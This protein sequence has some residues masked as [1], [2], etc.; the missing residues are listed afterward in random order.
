MVALGLGC[1][2]VHMQTT[3]E[4]MLQMQAGS[5]WE[6]ESVFFDRMAGQ[7]AAA[8]IDPLVFQRY[9]SSKRRRF[10]EEFRFRVLDDLCGKQVLDVGCADGHNSIL[11]AKL[12]ASVTGIDIS[13]K[14]IELARERACVNEVECST[15]FI[16]SPIE[17]ANI[18]PASFD[19]IWGDCVLHHL[20]AEQ[21]P[22]M[23]RLHG[24]LKP[25]GTMLFSEPVNFNNALR[26][27]RMKIP[28]HTEATPDE[29][30]LEPSEIETIRAYLPDMQIRFYSL[31]SRFS[32]FVLLDRFDYEHSSLP[33]RAIFNAMA[34]IDYA[35][36][37]VPPLRNMGRTHCKTL[38]K[39]IMKQA[40]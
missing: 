22:L 14:S 26:R 34:L 2:H 12:G 4:A 9:S 7:Q 20:I 24:W 11:L 8:A 19:V 16:C 18:P 25:G 3:G 40:I 15:R 1:P 30:P 5:R 31:L 10:R 33:R 13:P 6:Q 38:R 39:T 29:R 17:Q 32:R 36:L 23:E 37:S 28:I 21:E 35:S 27:L